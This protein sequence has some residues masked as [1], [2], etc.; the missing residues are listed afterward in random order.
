MVLETQC[1]VLALSSP[2]CHAPSMHWW[3]TERMSALCA[4]WEWTAAA[5]TMATHS[6][7][8]LDQVSHECLS[9]VDV[10]SLICDPSLL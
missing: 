1:R 3:A 6:P 8:D 7:V 10:H 5:A 9:L 2:H 4:A